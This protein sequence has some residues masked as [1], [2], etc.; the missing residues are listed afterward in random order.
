MANETLNEVL[1][2]AKQVI[3]T[4][5]LS[6]ALNKTIIKSSDMTWLELS[7]ELLPI[8][9]QAVENGKVELSS[10]DKSKLATDIVLPLIKDKLPWYVKPFAATLI[11]QAIGYVITALNKLVSSNWIDK[12]K[13]LVKKGK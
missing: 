5:E 9:V 12:V 3:N 13:T 4:T 11:K 6:K 8:V 2:G 1:E 7:Q 10:E